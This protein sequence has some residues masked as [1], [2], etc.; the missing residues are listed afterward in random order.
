[1]VVA[2][3]SLEAA[4]A[5]RTM[6][7][8]DRIRLTFDISDRARRA[9]G[10]VAARTTTTVGQVIENMLESMYPEDVALADRSIAEKPHTPSKRGRKPKEPK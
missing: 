9:L 2:Q 7:L 5:E 3:V 1:M 10:I 6:I 4:K 8:M